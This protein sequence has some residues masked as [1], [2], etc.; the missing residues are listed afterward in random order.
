[1]IGH[2][3]DTRVMMGPEFAEN[4]PQDPSDAVLA[5]AHERQRV[6]LSLDKGFVEPRAFTGSRNLRPF[7]VTGGVFG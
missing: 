5:H 6:L 7:A 4:W 2:A 3:S 1:M